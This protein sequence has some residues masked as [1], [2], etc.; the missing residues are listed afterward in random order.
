V[1]IRGYRRKDGRLGARN[2]VLVLPSVVCAD[3]AAERIGETGGV[4]VTHQHGCGQVGDDVEYTERSFLGF[5]TNPNVGGVVVVSLGCETIR[6]GRLASR[7]AELGQRV[8]FAGIQ[9]LGGT[10]NT[11]DYGR[12]AVARLRVE[13]DR[14]DRAAAPLSHLRVGV[15]HSGAPEIHMKRLVEEALDERATVVVAGEWPGAEELLYG[16]RARKRVASIPDPG[17]GA[18]QHVALAAAGAQIIVSFVGPGQAPVGL[19]TCPVLA[20]GL[21]PDLFVALEDDFDMDGSG[22]VWGR[23]LAIFDGEPS[24]SE[25]RGAHDFVL[26]RIARTM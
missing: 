24:A 11:V 19:A 14:E 16:Q 1:E 9:S 20:V 18:E 7:M 23:L 21:D 22:D 3:L 2:H 13:L 10:T 8:E 17:L 15:D 5:A 6:A 12:A 26:R 4:A 25:R